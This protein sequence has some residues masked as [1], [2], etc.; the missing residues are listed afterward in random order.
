MAFR[1]ELTVRCLM[2]V[3]EELTV[4]CLM[5]F[6]EELTV[7]CLHF[8]KNWQYTVCDIQWTTD[9]TL[10]TFSE[11]W[12]MVW[13]TLGK[14]E[15]LYRHFL[16]RGTKHLGKD[17]HCSVCDSNWTLSEMKCRAFP[18]HMLTL[19]FT[20]SAGLYNDTNLL[21]SWPNFGPFLHEKRN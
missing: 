7:R 1:E 14:S 20:A 8:V 12:L 16:C 5:A 9:S 4:R 19:A 3:S 10:M 13:K 2:P 21:G 18:P 11:D 6:S 15:V 17:N